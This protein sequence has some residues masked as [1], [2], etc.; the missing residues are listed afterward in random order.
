MAE[1]SRR[2]EKND[3]P[4][5]KELRK[6]F[7]RMAYRSGKQAAGLAQLPL[8]WN[9]QY[10]Q[11]KRRYVGFRNDLARAFGVTF[12]DE[13]QVF[14]SDN[15][16][17]INPT[18][19]LSRVTDEHIIAP[20]QAS[21]VAVEQAFKSARQSYSTLPAENRYGFQMKV[22]ALVLSAML[23]LYDSLFVQ[24]SSFDFAISSV[25]FLTLAMGRCANELLRKNHFNTINRYTF[26]E[27][28]Q[29][30][31]VTESTAEL[32]AYGALCLSTMIHRYFYPESSA[33]DTIALP[34][35][36]AGVTSE[37]FALAS[38]S[39]SEV[40]ELSHGIHFR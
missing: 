3:C 38:R 2:L 5:R 35:I 26:R 18:L 20:A 32:S 9:G 22:M 24:D 16:S 21:R 13:A 39:W 8:R 27:S 15:Q 28:E 6:K 36:M 37:F 30:G 14:L 4:L 19:T 34:M 33:Y 12:G 25:F 40:A 31:R 29:T 11:H 17:P 1:N 10:E 23:T 7:N